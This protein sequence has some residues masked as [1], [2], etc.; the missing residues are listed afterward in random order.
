MN[1]MSTIS[2]IEA[3]LG[4]VGPGFGMVGPAMNYSGLTSWLF[5]LF[6]RTA[7]FIFIMICYND[8]NKLK[9]IGGI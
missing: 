4:N 6:G 9:R 7:A 8:F 1:L 3:T 5:P 2:A